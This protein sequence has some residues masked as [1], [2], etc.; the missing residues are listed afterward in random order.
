MQLHCPANVCDLG[1][2][3]TAEN[4]VYCHNEKLAYYFYPEN[5]TGMIND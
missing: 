4:E 2:T 5:D 3:L 1:M